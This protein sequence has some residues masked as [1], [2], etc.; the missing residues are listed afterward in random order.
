VGATRICLVELVFIDLAGLRVTSQ[1]P[2][3]TAQE[4]PST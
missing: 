4:R 3:M 2:E 1:K